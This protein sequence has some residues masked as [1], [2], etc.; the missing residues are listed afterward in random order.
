MDKPSIGRIVIYKR[1]RYLER[2]ARQRE[3]NR[4]AE[5]GRKRPFVQDLLAG[6]MAGE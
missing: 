4:R 2:K 6:K 5:E 1:G 3:G